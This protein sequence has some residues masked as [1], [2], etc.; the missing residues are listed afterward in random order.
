MVDYIPRYAAAPL[1][2]F[3][4][5]WK[6]NVRLLHLSMRGLRVLNRM[7]GVFEDLLEHSDPDE[8][9]RL[10]SD[11]SEARKEAELAEQESKTGFP[12]LHANALVAMWWAMESAIED[13]LVGI[14]LNEA[15]ILKKEVFARICV[16]L[17]DLET[18]DREERM[19][20]L[21]T[22]LGRNL[23]RKRGVSAFE[24]LLRC[25]DLSGPVK[26]DDR[27]LIWQMHYLRDVIVH[28]NGCADRRLVEACPW[29]QLEVNE[30]VVISH[31]MFTQFAH[32]VCGYV[33]TVTHRL[34][35]RYDVDT[36]S[37]RCSRSEGLKSCE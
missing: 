36:H 29:L 25:F 1:Q 4:D 10:T 28:R 26:D 20:L 2:L 23:G 15:E 18:R 30:P 13:M 3:V 14:L 19:R 8:Q 5:S 21:L 7:P 34:V 12:L 24:C 37:H 9:A 27:K 17:V 16:P 35:M 6:S 22:E 32:A 33:V 11:L 31:A